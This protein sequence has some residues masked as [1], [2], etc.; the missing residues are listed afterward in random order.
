MGMPRPPPEDFPKSHWSRAASMAPRGYLVP[1][2]IFLVASVL[3]VA[4]LVALQ[5]HAPP[6]S[7]ATH[8]VKTKGTTHPPFFPP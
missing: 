1:S 4:G 2:G 6:H 5:V 3:L 8:V 7:H